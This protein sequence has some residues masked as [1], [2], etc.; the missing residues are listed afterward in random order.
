V[1]ADKDGGK[2]FTATFRAVTFANKAVQG[3]FAKKNRGGFFSAE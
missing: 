2:R 1:V 3:S